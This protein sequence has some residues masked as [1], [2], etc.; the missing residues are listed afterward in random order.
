MEELKLNRTY[1]LQFGGGDTVSSVTIL[2][3]TDKAYHIRWN[4]GENSNDTWE[5]KK[6][7]NSNYNLIED[8][9]NHMTNINVNKKIKFIT[10]PICHGMGTIPDEKSTAGNI[11]CP[12]CYG[13]KMIPES[14]E[15]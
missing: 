7:M 3:V 6:V 14:I 13:S 5:Q 4:R 2:M 8:I 9:T 12:L 11:P 1:L 15:T 10:C